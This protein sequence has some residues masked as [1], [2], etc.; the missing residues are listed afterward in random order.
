MPPRRLNAPLTLLHVLDEARFPVEHDLSGNLG[1][2][3]REHLLTEPNVRK[4]VTKAS[5]VRS[6]LAGTAQYG[7]CQAARRSQIHM[8]AALVIKWIETYGHSRST[9]SS[10]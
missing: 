2:D 8:A 3:A 10:V 1:M 4:T 6:L 9:A 5:S 7:R